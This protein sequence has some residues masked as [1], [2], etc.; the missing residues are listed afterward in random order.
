MSAHAMSAHAM[1]AHAMSAHAMSA[2]AT[3][4][5]FVIVVDNSQRRTYYMMRPLNY[6]CSYRSKCYVS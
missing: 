3:R 2:H 1:S 6:L 5:G 4:G